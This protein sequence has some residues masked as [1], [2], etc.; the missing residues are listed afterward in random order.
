[1]ELNYDCAREILLALEKGLNMEEFEDHGYKGIKYASMNFETLCHYVDDYPP[2]LVA[3]VSLKLK[4]ADYIK[5]DITSTDFSFIDA[6]YYEITFEG[7]QYLDSVRDTK[8]WNEVKQR[9]PVLTFEIIKYVAMACVKKF[10]ALK[11]SL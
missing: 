6:D 10:V 1:M 5:V 7:H 8:I 2:E 4:E 3:Y 11:L 9:T